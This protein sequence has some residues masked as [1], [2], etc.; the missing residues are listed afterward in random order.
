MKYKKKKN[1]SSNYFL[2]GF[3]VCLFCRNP[4]NEKSFFNISWTDRKRHETEMYHNIHLDKQEISNA[5]FI[6][7]QLHDWVTTHGQFNLWFDPSCRPLKQSHKSSELSL[8][9]KAF[10]FSA[11]V[12]THVHSP[13]LKPNGEGPK[14]KE[15]VK[16]IKHR[17]G[18]LN[19]IIYWPPRLCCTMTL[20]QIPTFSPWTYRKH[21]I[22]V[23][24]SIGCWSALW[25]SIQ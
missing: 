25:P 23:W 9:K 7:E 18:L 4:F 14:K 12:Y 13:L 6:H 22:I 8:A 19:E 24:A 5:V 15:K 3:F 1:I 16:I 21:S 10:A 17:E 20:R 11:W 2:E